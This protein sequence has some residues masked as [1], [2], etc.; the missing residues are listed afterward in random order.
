MYLGER[1]D[2][3]ALYSGGLDSV[4]AVKVIA[5]QGKKILAVKFKHPFNRGVWENKFREYLDDEMCSL[6]WEIPIGPEFMEIIM[7][8]RYGY[9]RNYNPCIDCKIFMYRKAA[10]IAQQVGAQGILTGEV[11]GQRPM[12][13]TKDTLALMER[14]SFLKGL[15]LRP[16]TAKN[17]PPTTLEE[18]G[19]V[20]RNSLYD[21][22]GRGRVPQFV[23][24]EKFGVTRY[25]APAGGCLLTDPGY[26]YRLNEAIGHGSLNIRGAQLLKL[27][28]HFRLP[29][30][31]KVVV[32]RFD[33]ENAQLLDFAGNRYPVLEDAYKAGPAAILLG[34]PTS[35]NLKTSARIVTRYSK[36]Q[37]DPE[38]TVKYRIP[39]DE[40][41]KLIAVTP[42]SEEFVRKFMI[43]AD[44]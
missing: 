35:S 14:E 1:F 13:Q 22:S 5:Q 30:G 6:V 9:G 8:P 24:A 31:G 4:L 38:A 26:S 36:S 12:S 17:L 23:L 32:G 40:N 16:L 37:Q 29:S 39:G 21:F 19:F 2:L 43:A 3:V 11:V 41:E 33:E 34:E 42:G 25:S 28:R 44:D 20:D 27:G 18:S 7:H 15:V 10:W